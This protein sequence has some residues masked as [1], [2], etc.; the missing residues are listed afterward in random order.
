MLWFVVSVIVIAIGL[1]A[2][3]FNE[4]KFVDKALKSDE[5][6]FGYGLLQ[7]NKYSQIM[8]AIWHKD[9]LQIDYLINEKG[10]KPAGIRLY[11]KSGSSNLLRVYLTGSGE[12]PDLDFVSFLISRGFSA[13][14]CEQGIGSPI[15]AAAMWGNVD[16][17]EILLKNGAKVNCP[18]KDKAVPLSVALQFNRCA[19]VKYLVGKGASLNTISEKEGFEKKL[20]NCY[21]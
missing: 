19:L 17:M 12:E 18:Y 6:P 1:L 14:D 10:Y 8:W 11:G 3:F 20:K 2:Y 7:Y 5:K 4:I 21:K 16:V 15:Y 13:D 9:R